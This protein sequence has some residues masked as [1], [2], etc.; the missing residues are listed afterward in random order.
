[1][2]LTPATL[3]GAWVG[4]KTVGRISDRLFVAVVGVGL[5]AAGVLFL[6]GF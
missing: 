2:A 5:I 4:K 6:A 1:M 3:L